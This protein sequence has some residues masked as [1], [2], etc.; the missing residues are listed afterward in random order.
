MI[1]FDGTVWWCEACGFTKPRYPKDRLDEA[2]G[3]I[4][5]CGTK[6]RTMEGSKIEPETNTAS[7]TTSREPS[8]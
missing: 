4:L 7:S 3:K 8:T 1:P 5:C 6:M 2:D